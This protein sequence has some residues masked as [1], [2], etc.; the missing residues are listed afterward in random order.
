MI[1]ITQLLSNSPINHTTTTANKYNI[2]PFVNSFCEFKRIVNLVLW[3]ELLCLQI[4][5]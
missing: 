5:L 2:D 4:V 3:H 1:A